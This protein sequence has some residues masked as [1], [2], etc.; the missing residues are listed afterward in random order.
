MASWY[1]GARLT[2]NGASA[3]MGCVGPPRRM[4]FHVMKTRTIGAVTCDS[5][6]TTA[7]VALTAVAAAGCCCTVA[8]GTDTATDVASEL[9]LL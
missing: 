5:S 9:L 2:D 3:L 1:G 7:V 6:T 8:I 4:R